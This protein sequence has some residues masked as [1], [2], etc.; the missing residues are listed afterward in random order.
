VNTTPH[1]RI[2]DWSEIIKSFCQVVAI[3]VAGWWTYHLFLKKE[4]PGLEARGSASSKIE[5]TSVSG[6]SEYE[7]DFQVNLENTGTTSFNISTIR[8]RGWEFDVAQPEQRIAFIDPEKVEARPTFFDK[9]YRLDP[10][11]ALPFLLITLPAL[12]TRIRLFGWLFQIAKSDS[13]S[14]HN[15]TNVARTRSPT[16]QHFLGTKSVPTVMTKMT[17][18]RQK[19]HDALTNRAGVKIS[20]GSMSTYPKS[21]RETTRGMMYFPRMLD[22]IRLHARGELDEDYDENLGHPKAADGLCCNFY[23]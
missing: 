19:I 12:P 16:G 22:K 9:T 8:V 11:S 5:W 20:I 15:S 17:C 18:R 3:V 2:K 7:V 4:A 23:E 14:R 10:K 1:E 13:T 21:P 6:S